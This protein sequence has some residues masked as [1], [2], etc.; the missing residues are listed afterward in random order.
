MISQLYP[1]DRRAGL[2]KSTLLSETSALHDKH[3]DKYKRFLIDGAMHTTLL[4]GTSGAI[5]LIGGDPSQVLLL[6]N[7]LSSGLNNID[8]GGI[9]T[10]TQGGVTIATWFKAMLDGSGRVERSARSVAKTRAGVTPGGA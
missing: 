5:G 1:E 10:T 8:L 6:P 3:P 9:D 2:F 7:F 4:G